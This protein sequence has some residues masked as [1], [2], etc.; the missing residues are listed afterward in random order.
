MVV[1]RMLASLDDILLPGAH[2]TLN[3]PDGSIGQTADGVQLNLRTDLHQHV[4]LSLFQ[5]TALHTAHDVIHPRQAFTAGST[6]TAGFMHV[7]VGQVADGSNLP[8]RSQISSN[9]ISGLIHGD[10]GS[11]AKTGLEGAQGVVIHQSHVAH[12]LCLMLRCLSYLI[13]S[14]GGRTTGNDSLEI[15]PAS[16]HTTAVLLE[17]FLQRN[18][19]L[20]LDNTG[21]VNVTAESEQLHT[22]VV[23][24]TQAVEP[25][26]A[27]TQ[28]GGSHGH[29]LTVGDSGRTA[30]QTG[31][32]G[33]W[34]LQTG[35]T[36]LTLQRLQLSGLFTTHVSTSSA[37]DE[38]IKVVT[39]AASIAT[40]QT[41]HETNSALLPLL[42]GFVDGFFQTNTLVVEFTTD[43]NVGSTGVHGITS[44]QTTLH[45]SV[46][47]LTDDFTIL[48]I[49]TIFHTNLAGT[50]F[51]FI[52]VHDKEVGTAILRGFGHETPLQTRRESSTATT[53]KT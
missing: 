28:N 5:L 45:Q 36:L 12:F 31:V 43:V 26:G 1:L 41:T 49:I 7:E 34:G 33:E 24:T 22:V 8:I 37:V 25:V 44:D 32:S 20:L 27:T 29:S 47:I 4:D 13:Q 51:R 52:A 38:N 17:K 53:T 46:G 48:R 9:H 39:R 21:V 35:L 42:I 15:V 6:L 50:R 23:L 40:N 30:V 2:Q 16:A 3:R 18:G 11:R 14:T 10:D 19:H